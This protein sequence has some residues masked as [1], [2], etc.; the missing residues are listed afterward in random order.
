MTSGMNT[1][2]KTEINT[3]DGQCTPSTNREI[4]I[5]VIQAIVITKTG[6]CQSGLIFITLSNTEEEKAVTAKVW[7]LGKLE[8]QY[9][10]VSHKAGLGRLTSIFIK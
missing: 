1:P 9:H 2:I 10:T 6:F 4:A 7:P 3:S 8:P 5:N